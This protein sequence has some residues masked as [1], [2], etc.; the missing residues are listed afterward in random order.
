MLPATSLLSAGI[1]LFDSAILV[2]CASCTDP[3]PGL[4]QLKTSGVRLLNTSFLWKVAPCMYRARGDNLYAAFLRPCSW[5]NTWVR[6]D[7]AV[8]TVM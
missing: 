5:Y 2:V 7:T 3:C 6:L 4:R 1:G 8:D